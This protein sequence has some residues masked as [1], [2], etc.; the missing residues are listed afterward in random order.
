MLKTLRGIGAEFAGV[1]W[2]EGLFPELFQSAAGRRLCRISAHALAERQ[3]AA[4]NNG[5]RKAASN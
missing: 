1:L 2:L 3:A 5:L 4:A